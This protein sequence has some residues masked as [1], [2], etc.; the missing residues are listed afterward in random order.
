[1]CLRGLCGLENWKSIAQETG[2][3]TGNSGTNRWHFGAIGRG[4]SHRYDLTHLLPLGNGL[5]YGRS[6]FTLGGFGTVK[7][8]NEGARD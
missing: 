8:R 2:I 3:K 1:V 7:A 6:F 5:F 4:G